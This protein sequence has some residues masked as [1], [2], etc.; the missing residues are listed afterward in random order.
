MSDLATSWFFEVVSIYIPQQAKGTPPCF[1][2]PL[3][4]CLLIGRRPDMNI[5]SPDANVSRE[6]ASLSLA[7]DGCCYVEDL[8][9]VNGVTINGV[10]IKEKRM[11]HDGDCVGLG[12]TTTLIAHRKHPQVFAPIKIS[13]QKETGMRVVTA[14]DFV[15][16]G[17]ALTFENSTTELE[18][19]LAAR[20][21]RFRAWK[22]NGLPIEGA[23]AMLSIMHA[24]AGSVWVHCTLCK[25]DAE[26]HVESLRS[27][28]NELGVL[29]YK[30]EE[31]IKDLLSKG[32]HHLLLLQG[33]DPPRIKALVEKERLASRKKLN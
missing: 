3:G 23:W 22:A 27:G 7:E 20:N 6:H 9:S 10:L 18:L 21:A 16:L 11:L 4:V 17:C 30:E 28:P 33:E 14:Q 15:K 13:K 1:E 2:L 12:P 26:G 24:T 5:V 29:I 19:L 8:R 25:L 32:C 31:A